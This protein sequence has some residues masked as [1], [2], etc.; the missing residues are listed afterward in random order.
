MSRRFLDVTPQAVESTAL[1]GANIALS[2]DVFG[3]RRPEVVELIHAAG[4]L[5]DQFVT[6]KRTT[7]LVMKDWKQEAPNTTHAYKAAKA[8]FIP[9]LRETLFH[10]VLM[11][12]MSLA[13]ALQATRAGVDD[14]TASRLTSSAKPIDLASAFHADVT[15]PFT[16][17]F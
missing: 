15:S 3:M 11:G 10:A 4:G 12:R 1:R 14:V 17:G 9:V 13:D 7:C 8:F 5:F 2:G 6:I 16:L